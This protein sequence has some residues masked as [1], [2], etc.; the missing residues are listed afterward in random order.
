MHKLCIY[1]YTYTFNRYAHTQDTETTEFREYRKFAKYRQLIHECG[2]CNFF[3]TEDSNTHC[4]AL[5]QFYL[6]IVPVIY[7]FFFFVNKMKII[8]IAHQ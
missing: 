7:F 6:F 2:I 1:I 4:P 5:L 3:T 8:V